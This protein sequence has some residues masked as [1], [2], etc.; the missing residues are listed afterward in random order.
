MQVAVLGAG[1][2]GTALA[3]SLAYN[4]H[5]VWLWLR[6]SDQAAKILYD[7]EN[8]KYLP[9]ITLHEKIH[10]TAN[11]QDVVD[12]SFLVMGVPTQQQ[13]GFLQ[14][15]GAFLCEKNPN[16][17]FINVAKGLEAKS[18][19]RLSV[20]Y[21][22]ELSIDNEKYS[23]L[24]G[25]SHAEE[26]GKLMPTALVAASKCSESAKKIQKLFMS[27]VLRVYT[28]DDLVGVE[29]GG[30]LKNIIALAIGMGI[31]LGYGDNARAGLMTRGI[32]EITRMGVI[33]GGHPQT[34]LGLTGVGDLIVTCTSE[35]SRNRRAGVL[36]GKGVPLDKVQEQLGMVVEGVETCRAAHQLAKEKNIVM[37]IV[38]HMYS[39][40]FEGMAIEEAAH[41]L[42]TRTEKSERE[43]LFYEEDSIENV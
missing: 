42:M 5:D 43:V 6:D 13:R 28:N 29:L 36:I 4:D 21:Q 26:V 31:G 9:G 8:K 37:P 16:A 30:A 3:Q 24:Y 27:D 12:C 22:E 38:E 25:P 2:W 7:K 15:Y 1:S 23:I 40:L 19:K 41:R 39:V 33:L 32:A 17:I 10:V 18:G 11:I 14:R 35:H 20:I 34:F